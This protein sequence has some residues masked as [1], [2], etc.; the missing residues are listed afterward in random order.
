MPIERKFLSL[1]DAARADRRIDAFL[2]QFYGQ[3]VAVLRKRPACCT[4]PAARAG[5]WF[6]GYAKAG[7]CR[8]VLRFA[9]NHER[10]P[11]TLAEIRGELGWTIE[12]RGVNG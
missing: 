2:E 6:E 5:Q 7:A 1:T 9:G 3:P 11:E 12:R 4:C 8:L 10:H